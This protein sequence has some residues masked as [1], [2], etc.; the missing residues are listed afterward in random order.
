MPRLLAAL[1]AL[2]LIAAP[3]AASAQ[4]QKTNAPPGNS[5]IDEYLETV[6]AASGNSRP[7]PPAAGGG[8]SSALTA[9]ERARLEKL[10]PDGKTLA[11]AIDA[12]SPDSK[13]G[14]GSPSKGSVSAG[15]GRSPI[16][17]VFDVA[18]GRDGG[19]GM[20]MLL[21]AILLASLL[22]FITLAV[23]RRRSAS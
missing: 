12:T 20:G 9:A 22:G 5:A 8:S 17:Q 19:G 15:E 16:S 18:A 14:S 6:P 23:M 1:V 2:A 7:R 11:D 4:T 10:G 13:A 21:P 3:A